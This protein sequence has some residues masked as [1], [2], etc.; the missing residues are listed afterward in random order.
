MET[1]TILLPPTIPPSSGEMGAALDRDWGEQNSSLIDALSFWLKHLKLAESV[2]AVPAKNDPAILQIRVTLFNE[3]WHDITEVGFGLSQVLPVLVAG[4]LQ[5]RQG[6]FIVDLP[7]AH[8]HP[9]PQAELADF[10]CSI[11]LTDRRV[12]VETH[13]DMFVNQLRLRAEM[14]PELRDKIAVYF[15]D[16][17]VHGCCRPPRPIELSLEGELRWPPDFMQEAWEIETKISAAQEA[18]RG[19]TR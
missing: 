18:R 14:T 12:L 6:L 1:Q 11:A 9:R 19:F 8:L 7:E 2:N 10:F 16:P 15:V 17:P 5:P 4:L 3:Q 13:S